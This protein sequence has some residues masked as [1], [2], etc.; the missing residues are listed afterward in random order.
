[1]KCKLR[2]LFFYLLIIN[3]SN[4]APAF[5]GKEEEASGYLQSFGYFPK[6]EIKWHISHKQS[7]RIVHWSDSS[8][9][10]SISVT[11]RFLIKN[12]SILLKTYGRIEVTGKIDES[13]LALIKT[14]RCGVPD[15]IRGRKRQRRYD[16]LSAKWEKHHVTWKL[17]TTI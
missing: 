13:T 11:G 14:P 12:I 7:H 3:P 6:S 4:C 16:L 8:R 5:D 9:S 1:M 10:K 2:I 17:V 15:I